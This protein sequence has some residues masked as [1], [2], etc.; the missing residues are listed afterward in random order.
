MLTRG[1]NPEGDGGAR[2]AAFALRGPNP[3]SDA[4]IGAQILMPTAA[5][6]ALL[7]SLRCKANPSPNIRVP[8]PPARTQV[9]LPA[10]ATLLR[11]A[12]IL[13]GRRCRFQR[14]RRFYAPLKSCSD[15]GAASSG[16]GATMRR[17]KPAYA[18][19]ASSGR[20][21][22]TRRSN[23]DLTQVPLQAAA[24][25]LRAAQ[26][27]PSA[28]VPLSAVAALLCA[29]KPCPGAGAAS[30]GRDASMRHSNPSQ[31][32]GTFKSCPTSNGRDASMRRRTRSS[33]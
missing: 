24:A 8:R 2:Y 23:P 28:Q 17:S 29:L 25:L 1:S 16:G 15:A 6:A 30:S 20:D 19:A 33:A 5:F 27:V 10:V 4:G 14:W 31:V 21:A 13:L 3:D 9:P 7:P 11:A 18:G 32:A 12:Q 22:S 26:I